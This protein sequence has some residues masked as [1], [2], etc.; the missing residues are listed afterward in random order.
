VGMLTAKHLNDSRRRELKNKRIEN[1]W[2]C[3]PSWEIGPGFP[4]SETLKKE[5]I[6]PLKE[7]I[8]ENLTNTWPKEIE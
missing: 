8:H 7:E 1:V 6:I 4:I 5:I 2:W 3:V